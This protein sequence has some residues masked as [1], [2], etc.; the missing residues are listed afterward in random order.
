[1]NILRTA[2]LGSNFTGSDKEKSVPQQ[3]EGNH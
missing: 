1:M 3:E 2:G